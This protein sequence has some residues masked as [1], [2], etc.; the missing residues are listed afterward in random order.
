MSVYMIT[1][2]GD[3]YLAHGYSDTVQL[4]LLVINVLCRRTSVYNRSTTE[5]Q[6]PRVRG[7]SHEAL[8]TCTFLYTS[9]SYTRH[10]ASAKCLVY[11][12]LIQ[13]HIPTNKKYFYTVHLC[14]TEIN[15]LCRSSQ[16]SSASCTRGL[17][18]DHYNTLK[19]LPDVAVAVR[20]CHVHGHAYKPTNKRFSYTVHLCLRV[21]QLRTATATSG[22]TLKV[23]PDVAACLTV[24]HKCTA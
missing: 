13:T 7:A 8:G 22:N 18:L 1:A 15:V 11:E 23:L 5:V 4:F 20:S 21:R 17:T 14:L 3:R 12:G 6:V 16:V 2:N 9:P 24:K 10:L 19:A